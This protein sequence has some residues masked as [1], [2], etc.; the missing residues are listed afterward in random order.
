MELTV[1]TDNNTLIDR[2]FLG[3]PGLSFL[4]QEGDKNIL[5][6]LGYSDVFLKN[7]LKLGRS[8]RNLDYVVL[9]HGHL[10]H[11]WGLQ[12]LIRHFSETKQ[13]GH[14]HRVPTLLGHPL[15]F[16]PK[17]EAGSGEIGSMISREEAG[18]YFHL[19]LVKTPFWL[20]DNLVFLGEIERTNAFENRTPIGKV[21]KNHELEADYLLDDSA[22]VYKGPEG[23]V[24]ITGCA[25]AGIC[26]IIQQAKK[27]CKEDRILD[28]IGG[29]HLL[30]PE[31]EQMEKTLECMKKASPQQLHPCHCTDLASKF[32]LSGVAPVKEVGAGLVLRYV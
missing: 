4:I 15:V 28:I 5:F 26:N 6:D 9:S 17:S 21:E 14:S 12:H 32:A 2:Y 24:I 8:L 31:K 30:S 25:H 22:L 19:N 1:L 23:L 18:R 7:A 20:T 10:D 3:E 29:F 13:E 27:V 11:T 16:E